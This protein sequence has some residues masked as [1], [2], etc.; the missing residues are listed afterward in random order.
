MKILKLL[1]FTILILGLLVGSSA[2][3][4]TYSV[5]DVNG[6]YTY[7]SQGSITMMVDQATMQ[8]QTI[9]VA[10]VGQFVADGNGGG[11]YSGV[12]NL[13]GFVII[14]FQESDNSELTYTVD[15]PTTGVGTASAQVTATSVEFPMGPEFAP[16]GFSPNDDARRR[17][18]VAGGSRSL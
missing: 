16:P 10:S 6:A 2:V 9:P 18:A 1:G 4:Q 11:D 12:M 13:G 5:A 14:N 7:A 17:W 15:E 3:A 8:M